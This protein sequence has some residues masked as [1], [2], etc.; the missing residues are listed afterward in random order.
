MSVLGKKFT[1]FIADGKSMSHI[2]RFLLSHGFITMHGISGQWIGD[3]NISDHCPVW[4]IVSP[5]HWGLKPFRVLNGWFDHPD[6]LPFVER[7]WKGFVVH[8]KKTVKE[9]N[10]IDGFLGGDDM[11]LEITRTEGLQTDF[12]IQL[13]FKESLL[14]QKSTMR[15]VKEG[16]MNSKYLH[17][18]IKSRRR[19]NNLAALKDG[20]QWIQGV[21]EVKGHMKNFFENNFSERWEH[22]PNINGI[23]FQTLSEEDNL[24]LMT[25]FS[26]D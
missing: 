21:A 11:G 19:K 12:W 18:S 9:L 1:W 3:R 17:E 20:D 14:K 8:G 22:R 4:L 2:D 5:K 7:Y 26:I 15:W 24:F 6:F 25:P 16:D 23:Q 10:D 13:H